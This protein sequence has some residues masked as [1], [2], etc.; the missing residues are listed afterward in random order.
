MRFDLLEM[1]D[2]QCR[3]HKVIEWT[4]TRAFSFGYMGSIYIHEK[5]KYPQGTVRPGG[6]YNKVREDL[7]G[8]L[9]SLKDPRT[10]KPVVSD[11]F[12]KEEIYT[13]DRL[14][15]A[16]DIIFKPSDF[17]Y[18]VYGD[19]SSSWYHQPKDRCADHTVEGIIII[20]GED[21]RKGIQ[22]SA[23]VNDVT[24]TLL[25]MHG[26]PLLEDMDGRILREV[27]PGE[28]VKTQ[29]VQT[30]EGFPP[31]DH[32]EHPLSEEEEQEIASR[33]RDLGYL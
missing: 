3:L 21:I 18:T 23:N 6:E 33:L 4:R 5:G 10:R 2:E 31:G 14:E 15:A 26:L 19:F 29:K 12:R 1:L 25:S 27:F 22:L 11:I 30:I 24:P 8:R 28:V 20:K 7:I 13:G 16:P 32:I 17:A 9:R